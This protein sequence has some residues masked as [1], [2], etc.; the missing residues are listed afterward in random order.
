MTEGCCEGREGVERITCKCMYIQCDIHAH[1]KWHTCN[2]MYMYVHG[3]RHMRNG[4]SQWVRMSQD[5]CLE[6]GQHLV[7][8]EP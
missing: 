3:M 5:G 6:T 2:H 1:A 8:K 7:M 4:H